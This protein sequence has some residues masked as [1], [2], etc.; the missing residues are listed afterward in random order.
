MEP[1]IFQSQSHLLE[2]ISKKRA[3]ISPIKNN[4]DDSKISFILKDHREQ[5]ISKR[6]EFIN[7]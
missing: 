1:T 7:N 3:N 4:A 6:K 5:L 2:Q